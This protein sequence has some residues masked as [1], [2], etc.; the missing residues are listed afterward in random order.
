[1]SASTGRQ[2]L[3][4]TR[5]RNGLRINAFAAI[6][7]LLLE[8]GLG[9][10]VAIYARIPV[11]DHGKALFA[12]FGSAVAGGPVVLSLHAVLGTILLVTGVSALVRAVITRG[13]LPMAIAA[14]ALLAVV[15]AW[16]SGSEFVGTMANGPT[17]A[18]AVAT[19]VAILGYAL[20][21]FVIPGGPSQAARP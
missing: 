3:S 10:G 8:F 20:I 16:L 6:V 9:V 12:A 18:M 11:A 13:A 21:L 2:A 1:M 4:R 5:A 15:V 14:T 7:L 19:G 17:L